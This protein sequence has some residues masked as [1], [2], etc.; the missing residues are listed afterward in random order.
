M[1]PIIN[2]NNANKNKT[3]PISIKKLPLPIFTKSPKK[4]KEISKFFKN[5]KSA[6]VNKPLTKSYTQASKPVNYTKEVIKI[7][8][9]FSSLRASKID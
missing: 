2:G 5:L 7:K 8:D 1:K 4:V 9:A 3:V 6:S